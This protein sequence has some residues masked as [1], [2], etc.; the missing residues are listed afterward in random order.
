MALKRFSSELIELCHSGLKWD[1]QRHRESSGVYLYG[2]RLRVRGLDNNILS[3][4]Q[5]LTQS[6]KGQND[7]L[8]K[9]SVGSKPPTVKGC[10]GYVG[11]N[12]QSLATT[13]ENSN[14]S[15]NLPKVESEFKVGDRVTILFDTPPDESRGIL[16]S[17]SFRFLNR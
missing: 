2:I 1:V 5:S 14:Q 17:Q 3:Q 11:S 9:N 15:E 16:G 7:G 13:S 8:V 10:V 12:E 4:E 6:V